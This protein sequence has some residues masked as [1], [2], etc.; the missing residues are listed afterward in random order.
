MN[1]N[2]GHKGNFALK[3]QYRY[4]S[5]ISYLAREPFR[6]ATTMQRKAYIKIANEVVVG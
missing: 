1:S 4:R 5:E 6:K 3:S 2:P